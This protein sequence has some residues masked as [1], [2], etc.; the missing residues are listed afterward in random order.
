[1]ITLYREPESGADVPAPRVPR[2]AVFAISKP[3]RLR[4]RETVHPLRRVFAGD[5]ANIVC[6]SAC[7]DTSEYSVRRKHDPAGNEFSDEDRFLSRHL[8]FS[9][10]SCNHA[11]RLVEHRRSAH[12][13]R[14]RKNSKVLP[15]PAVHL[16]AVSQAPDVRDSHSAGSCKDGRV[17]S[18][19]ESAHWQFPTIRG[20]PLSSYLRRR[21]CHA[22]P[23]R[24]L[25]RAIASRYLF[26]ELSQKIFAAT[27]RN[28]CAVSST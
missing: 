13:S 26:F 24:C 28:T 17:L 12:S 5:H 23:C 8:W 4:G 6:K 19:L 20:A 1:M 2:N 25:R 22:L 3:A 15:A 10:T 9:C 11:F 14:D 16:L 18:H 7:P 27:V 21:S